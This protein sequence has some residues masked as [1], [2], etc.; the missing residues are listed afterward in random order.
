MRVEGLR[1]LYAV[2]PSLQ[3]MGGLLDIHMQCELATNGSV[4]VDTAFLSSRWGVTRKTVRSWIKSW[5]DE[6]LVEVD[7]DMISIVHASTPEFYTDENFNM[8]L[9]IWP[10]SKIYKKQDAFQNWQ[11]TLKVANVNPERLIEAA[12]NYIYQREVADKAEGNKPHQYTRSLK[13]FFGPDM[14]WE[15]YMQ[16]DEE[17]VTENIGKL[18]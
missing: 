16:S 2:R 13:N 15:A 17:W 3:Q 8:V 6:G 1:N 4:P 18:V 14:V 12:Q 11:N 5:Q 9:R 7:E 10:R